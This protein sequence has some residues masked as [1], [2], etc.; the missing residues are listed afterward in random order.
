MVNNFSKDNK[1]RNKKNKN[2]YINLYVFLNEKHVKNEYG[3]FGVSKRSFTSRDIHH[4][5]M[6]TIVIDTNLLVVL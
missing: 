3:K 1:I 2:T 4:G 6:H 5:K